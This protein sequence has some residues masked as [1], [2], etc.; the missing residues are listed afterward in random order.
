MS[1]K[2][3]SPA[4]TA[5]AVQSMLKATGRDTATPVTIGKPPKGKR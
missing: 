4:K 3:A 2:V 5:K 1:K